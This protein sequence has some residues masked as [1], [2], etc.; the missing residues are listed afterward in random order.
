MKNWIRSFLSKR[1]PWFIENSNLPA[2]ITKIAPI[3]VEAISLLCFVFCKTT[4]PASLKN[5]ETI[6]YHQ[7][8]E[9]LFLFHW[10]LYGVFWLIG[11]V[12]YKN[13]RDAYYNNPFER[14]AYV[15]QE[16]LNYLSERKF[17]SWTKYFWDK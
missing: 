14:E 5:H 12:K 17:Y 2:L 7:Q 16:N 1:T 9:L 11:L 8:I 4:L 6:H 10:I 3:N 15:N 13:S